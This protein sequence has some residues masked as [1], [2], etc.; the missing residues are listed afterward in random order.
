M[1]TKEIQNIVIVLLI[2]SAGLVIALAILAVFGLS[3]SGDVAVNPWWMGFFVMLI[4]LET[5]RK[6]EQQ[7]LMLKK[8]KNKR[9]EG[10][11][12]MNEAIKTH[13]GKDCVITTLNANIKGVIESVDDNW[14]T[15]KKANK[16]GSV[17]LVNADH[18]S[19]IRGK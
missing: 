9:M 17:E 13:I 10:N 18:V 5:Q 15:V 12:K 7:R 2:L 4:I 16:E 19:R 8:I 14:I 6:H 11:E 1:S 3:S